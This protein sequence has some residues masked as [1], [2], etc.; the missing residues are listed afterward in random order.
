M[1]LN[2]LINGRRVFMPTVNEKISPKLAY[3]IFKFIKRVESVD[4]PFYE[5]KVKAIVE[6]YA[7]KDVDGK[8]TADKNGKVRITEDKHADYI[9]EMTE[10]DNID[11]DYDGALFT[12][13]ELSEIKLSVMDIILLGELVTEG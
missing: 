9:A 4:L 7:E 12:V 3:K 8:F 1:K 2:T 10:L 13:D 11:T 6:K 5:E